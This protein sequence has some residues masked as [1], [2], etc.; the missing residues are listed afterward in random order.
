MMSFCMNTHHM[1]NDPPRLPDIRPAQSRAARLLYG[2]AGW[3][4]LLLGIIGI[5]VPGLPT[6]PF[7]LLAAAC[8]S[9]ASPRTHQWLLNH[10]VLGPFIR[11]W[12]EHR[13]LTVRS[14]CFAIGTMVLMLSISAWQFV[15]KPWIQGSILLLGAIGAFCVL[16]IPTRK[17]DAGK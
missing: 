12:E 7:V 2:A 13:S 1:K 8:F 10:R 11:N 6:T 5:F 9:K 16:R 17:L 14:K 3:L 15:G 4:S